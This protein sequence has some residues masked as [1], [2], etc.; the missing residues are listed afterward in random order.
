MCDWV[1]Y[2]IVSLTSNETYIGSS[3]NQFKR[4]NAHNN[5][6]KEVKRVGAKRT[7]GRVWI[8]LLIVSGF[9]TKIACLSFEAGWKRLVKYRS[10][11]KLQLINLAYDC[12]LKYTKCPIYNRILDLTWFM[13]SFT[14]IYDKFAINYEFKHPIIQPESLTLNLFNDL[15]ID[16]LPW[17]HFVSINKMFKKNDLIVF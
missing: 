14:Y 15:S 4:L 13:N 11:K 10:D 8:P 5:N 9:D 6:N 7:S 2:M 17:P 16:Q 1:C 3:N 12:N